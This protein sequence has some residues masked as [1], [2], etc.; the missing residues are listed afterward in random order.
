VSLYQLL[1]PLDKHRQHDE[2]AVGNEGG[3]QR[4]LGNADDLAVGKRRHCGDRQRQHGERKEQRCR[5]EGHEVDLEA[6]EGVRTE[7]ACG[8]GGD[9]QHADR[10]QADDELRDAGNGIVQHMQQ[11]QDA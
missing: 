7:G 1:G 3:Q 11:S 10:S 2:D 8:D 5:C 4:L 6:H 9:R